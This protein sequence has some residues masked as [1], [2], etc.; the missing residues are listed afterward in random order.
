MP[1]SANE[2]F[3]DFVRFTGDGLPNEPVGHPLPI[4][5]PRSGVHNPKKAD[6]REVFAGVYVAR[7]EAIGAVGSI[8]GLPQY[9][10]HAAAETVNIPSNISRTMVGGK[11][12]HRVSSNPYTDSAYQDASGDWFSALE[13][14]DT[15]PVE[16][17]VAWGQ[18]EMRGVSGTPGGD[19]TGR[20]NVILYSRGLP[21][22]PDGWYAAGPEDQAW[23]FAT[24]VAPT[25]S[26]FYLA[27]AARAEEIGGT[28]AIIPYAL[29]GRESGHFIQGGS[30]WVGL[31]ASWSDALAAPL[32]GRG[33]SLNGLGKTLADVMLIWQG[34]ADADYKLGQPDAATSADDWVVR[35]RTIINSLQNPSG[36]SVPIIDTERTKVVF[37]EMLHGATS[38][39]SPGVGNPTDSRNRD[40]HK[41]LQYTSGDRKQIR[42]VPMAGVNNFTALGDRIGSHD[43][44]HPNGAAYNEISSRLTA[45][46]ESMDPFGPSDVWFTSA[47]GRTVIR[48]DGTFSSWSADLSVPSTNVATGAMFRSSYSLWTF[49]FPAG[50][51]PA[52]APTVVPGQSS[53]L[54]ITAHVHA[55]TVTQAQGY[56]I[57]P[58]TS[59]SATTFRLR[60]DGVWRLT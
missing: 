43:N 41:L 24:T 16:V 51:E 40:L 30:M 36:A 54:G 28:V 22:V 12:Y 34:S 29:G 57:S 42:I 59:A 21:T 15:G 37:F 11:I 27:A 4:G 46:L 55:V 44:L 6:F 52:E 32:P 23:P 39:G 3:R 56:T 31:Q 19:R 10:D 35:W 2:V 26:P 8:V 5:D 7:D 25:G 58:V 48:P 38:G 9:P 49:P 17:W 53:Q 18:S 45:V 13:V 60:A 50:Y 33:Q 14:M 20:S 1:P 47:A